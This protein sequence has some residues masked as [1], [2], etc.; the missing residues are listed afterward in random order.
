METPMHKA[1][2]LVA[3]EG[4]EPLDLR[5]MSP[6]SYQLLHPATVPAREGGVE[7]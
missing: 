2:A 4:F 7:L 1:P 5:I 6:T 3:G